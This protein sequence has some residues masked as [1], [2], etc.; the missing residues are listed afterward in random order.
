M[1][2]YLSGEVGGTTL[3]HLEDDRRFGIASSLERSND[4]GGGSAVLQDRLAIVIFWSDSNAYNSW[5]SKLVLLSVVEE[6]EDIVS[7]NNTGLA[8][9]NVESTHNCS[10][11]R[12]L[13]L[14][15]R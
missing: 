1:Y 2:V 4:G 10:C 12:V 3:G 5:D 13:W 7:N 14:F 11:M 15:V 6:L 9:E 8:A